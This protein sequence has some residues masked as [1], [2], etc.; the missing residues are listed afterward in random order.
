[1]EPHDPTIVHS[2]QADQLPAWLQQCFVQLEPDEAALA[3]I[4]SARRHPHGPVKTQLHRWLRH[5]AA[6]FDIN[7]FLGMYRLHLLSTRQWG[8]LLD[9]S[10]GRDTLLD[11]GAGSGDLTSTLAALFTRTHTTEVSRPSARRLRR[12]GFTCSCR[13]VSETGI[14]GTYDTV[15]CLNVLDRCRRPRTLVRT[16]ATAVAPGGNLIV[17]TPLPFD[18]FYFDGPRT[19]EPEEPLEAAGPSWE[20]ALTQLMG[21]LSPQLPGWRLVR[22]TRA[23]YLSWGD[24]RR[25]LYVHDDAVLLWRRIGESAS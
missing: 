15:S 3:F 20:M 10:G 2:L 5:F 4:D 17:A 23:P 12:R 14:D 8:V 24:S 13:D 18:P 6:D 7:A 1:M 11:V 19:L 25:P 9:A 16:L 21:E 22:F